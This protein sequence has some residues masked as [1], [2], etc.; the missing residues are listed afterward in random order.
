MKRTVA[1]G[2]AGSSLDIKQKPAFLAE[3]EEALL[4][5]RYVKQ[6]RSGKTGRWGKGGSNPDRHHRQTKQNCKKFNLVGPDGKVLTCG[7]CGSYR[8]FVVDCPHNMD[9]SK[10]ET[11]SKDEL[12]QL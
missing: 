11:Y 12:I 9:E 2:Q 10:S 1:E 6:F 5:A 3:H 7:C 8:H 4:A